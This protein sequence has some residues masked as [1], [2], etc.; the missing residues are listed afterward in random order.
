M[1]GEIKGICPNCCDFWNNGGGC[2]LPLDARVKNA[3]GVVR[4]PNFDALERR[5][6]AIERK[7]SHKT[8]EDA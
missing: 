3:G 4:C 7:L 2:Y 8:R 6:E 1:S 5:V